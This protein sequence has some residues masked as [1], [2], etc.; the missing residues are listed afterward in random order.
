MPLRR[1]A[2][3]NESLQPSRRDTQ[4]TSFSIDGTARFVCSTFDE[5]QSAEGFP[6]EKTRRRHS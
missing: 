4:T 1:L 3:T 2:E 6:G 5:V